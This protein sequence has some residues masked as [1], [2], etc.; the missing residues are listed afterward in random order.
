MEISP[1]GISTMWVGEP[2]KFIDVFFGNYPMKDDNPIYQ[3]FFDKNKIIKSLQITFNDI[4]YRINGNIYINFENTRMT[5]VC[6]ITQRPFNLSATSR[7]K[8]YHKNFVIDS[9]EVSETL[10]NIPE[11]RQ[12]LL[13]NNI[14][15]Y[16]KNKLLPADIYDFEKVKLDSIFDQ[17]EE[18][19]NIAKNAFEIANDKIK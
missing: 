18:I 7:I 16:F 12:K 5:Y 19:L 13:N 15:S 2:I 17:A 4:D 8:I 10:R 14:M 3:V 1:D 11:L 6:E 9:F